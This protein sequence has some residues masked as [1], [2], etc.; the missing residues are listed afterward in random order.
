MLNMHAYN[1]I[2]GSV[3]GRFETALGSLKA[4]SK[5]TLSADVNYFIDF[6]QDRTALFTDGR[7]GSQT[8]TSA[9][10]GNYGE[11]SLDLNHDSQLKGGAKLNSSIGAYMQMGGNIDKT[12]GVS[13]KLSI[14]F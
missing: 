4:K 12:V 5:T 13:A 8:L 14:S 3:G 7:G 10:I 11:V 6:S 9:S 2:L 1:T